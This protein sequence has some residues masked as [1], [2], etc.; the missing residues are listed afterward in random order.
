M[1]QCAFDFSRT[2]ARRN[3][4]ATSRQAARSMAVSAETQRET[5]YWSL[6]RHG[7]PLTADEIAIRERMT[8]EQVCRRLADLERL[9]RAE[10]TEDT[11]T[12]RSGRAARCW[13]L[14]EVG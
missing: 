13:R 8:I 3:D 5:V 10:P 9:G 6:L 7:A 1:D 11:R 12:T 2:H 4:P 14:M